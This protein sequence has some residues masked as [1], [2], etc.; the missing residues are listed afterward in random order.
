MTPIEHEVAIDRVVEGL[1]QVQEALIDRLC[2]AV[3]EDEYLVV[4]KCLDMLSRLQL[5]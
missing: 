3:R 1:E 4:D 5:I 2:N